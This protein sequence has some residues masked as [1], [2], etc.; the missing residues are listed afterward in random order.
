MG[1]YRR[2][3]HP[4]RAGAAAGFVRGSLRTAAF[5]V[6]VLLAG[7]SEPFIVFAGGAL[8]GE[9]SP[10]PEDWSLLEK[11][12]TIQLETRP[13]DP[14][15]VNLWAVGIGPDLYVGTGPDGTRWSR[16]VHDN[17]QVRLRA[18]GR[19]YALEAQRV[20][21]PEERKR[22]AEAYGIKYDLDKNENWVIDAIVFRLDRP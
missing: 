13:E 3:D 19:I 17:P 11:I 7:C 20:T 8:S 4:R 18:A 15:S 6:A 1:M 21:E 22:V 5:A 14:Y 2:R 16:H 9:A 12:E 10:P